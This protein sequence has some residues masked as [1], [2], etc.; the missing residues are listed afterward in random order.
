MPQGPRVGTY[1]KR[2]E[3]THQKELILFFNE[4]WLLR[5][6]CCCNWQSRDFNQTPRKDSVDC[7]LMDSLL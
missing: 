4:H 5:A 3:G 2:A 1:A 6:L 7:G